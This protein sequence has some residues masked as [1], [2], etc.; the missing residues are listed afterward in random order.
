MQNQNETK[1]IFEW[2]S[3]ERPS[4]ILPASVAGCIFEF[5]QVISRMMGELNIT[6]T[7]ENVLMTAK[8]FY[9]LANQYLNKK[10]PDV[11]GSLE[12]LTE[13]Q[14]QQSVYQKCQTALDGKCDDGLNRLKSYLSLE[15]NFMQY[16]GLVTQKELSHV[17]Q[18]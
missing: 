17:E 10:L 5:S 6:P 7:R 1:Q 11:N 18:C 4:E 8:Q 15:Q 9:I 12:G 16:L 14:L 13:F 2:I 3:A